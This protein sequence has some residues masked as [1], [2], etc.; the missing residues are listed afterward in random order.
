MLNS[1]V[2]SALC[3]SVLQF[4]NGYTMRTPLLKPVSVARLSTFVSNKQSDGPKDKLLSNS[5]VGVINYIPKRT[6]VRVHYRPSAWK[7]IHRHGMEKRLS[8]RGGIEI[9]WRRFMKGRHVLTVYDR[10]MNRVPEKKK[11]YNY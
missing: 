4:S 7:R 10:I 5:T 2:L 9:L 6:R 3:R 8:S 11:K 1:N